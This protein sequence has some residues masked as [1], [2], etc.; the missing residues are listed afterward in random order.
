MPWLELLKPVDGH[1]ANDFLEVEAAPHKAYIDAGLARDGGSGPETV[2]LQRAVQ[3]L[4]DG[5]G[6]ITRDVADA[7]NSAV[8]GLNDQRRSLGIHAT[9]S[10]VDKKRSFGD[11]LRSITR[12]RDPQAEEDQRAEAVRMLS[13]PWDKGGYGRDGETIKRA[14]V[15]GTGAGGGFLTPVTYETQLLMLMPEQQVFANR[16]R[17]VPLGTRESRFPSLNQYTAPSAGQSAVFAGIQTFYRGETITRTEA[18]ASFQQVVLVAQD[19]TAYFQYSRDLMEDAPAFSTYATQLVSGALGWREDWEFLQGNGAGRPQGIQTAPATITASP[20][21]VVNTISYADLTLMMKYMI[22][23]YSGKYIWIAHP[24]HRQSLMNMTDSSGRL[25]WM[26]NWPGAS[27]GPAGAQ[28]PEVLLNA[29]LL[30]SEKVQ[31]PGTAGDL[32][33]VCPECYFKGTRAGIEIGLSDQYAFPQDEIAL[34]AKLR[35]DGQPWLRAAYILADGV[36][37]NTVTAFINLHA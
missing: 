23:A 1:S 25:V 24:Y 10:E 28:P 4:K 26:P 8:K 31:A 13:T 17:N 5:I 14:N 30:Y 12:T 34:R 7:M 2:L 22:P 33:L 35:H 21:A 3:S 32:W 19:L 37:T 6:G 27:F 15:E 18:D 9:E 11:F 20:R 16:C 36:G 29:P